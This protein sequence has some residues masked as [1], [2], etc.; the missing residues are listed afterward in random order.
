MLRSRA[1][2]FVALALA[3]LL[4]VA[5][6][7]GGC[8]PKVAATVDGQKILAS[9]VDTEIAKMKKDH[10]QIFEGATGKKMEAQFRERILDN[11]V[12]NLLVSQE[13]KR[14]GIAVSDAEIMAKLGMMQAQYHSEK[15]FQD[16]IAASGSTIDALKERIRLQILTTRMIDK[17]TQEVTVTVADARDY[18]RV[19]KQVFKAAPTVRIRLIKVLDQK[20]ADALAAQL[21]AGADFA[22]LA[23]AN[24]VDPSKSQGG[25]LGVK[26]VSSLPKEVIG[27]ARVAPVG[28]VVGPIRGKGGVYIISVI[29]RFGERQQTFE[30]V[31]DRIFQILKQ[32]KQVRAFNDWIESLKKK[33]KVNKAA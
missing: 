7:A 19:N 2:P 33:A 31:K 11:L 16:A 22:A 13:A 29:K 10:P 9:Q 28:Q 6:L 21:K 17:V 15:Q 5:V 12:S 20:K 30:E 14:Q 3:S 26:A 24:S 18:Y 4:A 27:S 1:V 8:G 23:R 25:D 32:E